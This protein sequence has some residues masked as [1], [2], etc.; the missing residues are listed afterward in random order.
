MALASHERMEVELYFRNID[1][2]L[3]L[4]IVIRV[5]KSS[6]KNFNQASL[7]GMVLKVYGVLKS[8]YKDSHLFIF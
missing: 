4:N 5:F 1:T 3:L 7:S 8:D 6:S 2:F